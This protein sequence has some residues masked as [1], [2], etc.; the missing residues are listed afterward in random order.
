MDASGDP[1]PW[2]S[3]TAIEVLDQLAPRQAVV[4]E[5]GAGAST[6]WWARRG[7]RV[8]SYDDAPA[9]VRRTRDLL[10]SIS[11]SA[12]V[13]LVP[14]VHALAQVVQ[15]RLASED[16]CDILVSDGLEPRTESTRTALPL[17]RPS[18]LLVVDNS[19][20][21]ELSR[22]VDDLISEGWCALRIFGL[23]PTHGVAHETSFLSRE[24][25]RP[26]G[27]GRQRSLPPR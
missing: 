23:V 3:L 25:L 17:L 22:L 8:D 1:T 12:T 18:G 20:R 5:L 2:M 4:A 13:T 26:Q 14:D 19:D 24:P 15:H 27:R 7:N 11:D 10:T 16:G 9:W 21:P 6:Q